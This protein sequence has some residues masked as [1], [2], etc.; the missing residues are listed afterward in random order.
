LRGSMV[1]RSKVMVQASS[2]GIRF[3]SWRGP[4]VSEY[5]TSAVR[6]L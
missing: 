2:R 5:N 1:K 4:Q 6:S 3:R